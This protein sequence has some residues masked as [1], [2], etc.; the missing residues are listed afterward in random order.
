MNEKYVQSEL[1]TRS[2]T[3]DEIE[4]ALQKQ[5]L[6]VPQLIIAGK[7]SDSKSQLVRSDVSDIRKVLTQAGYDTEVVLDKSLKRQTLVQKHADI[8]F[9]LILFA[10]NVPLNVVTSYIANWLFARFT[11]GGQVN[12]KYEHARFGP[13]GKIVDYIKLEGKASEVAEILKSGKFQSAHRA[14]GD[15]SQLKRG[16]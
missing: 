6:V 13:D 11:T 12:V 10:A 7:E 4:K 9:P 8:V 14:G 16:K 1:R 3:E 5:V 15:S 2:Y